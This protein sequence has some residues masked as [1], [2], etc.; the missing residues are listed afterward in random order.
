MWARLGGARFSTSDIYTHTHTH[1]YICIGLASSLM[2]AILFITI[3][4]CQSQKSQLIYSRMDWPS[5]GCPPWP[6]LAWPGTHAGTLSYLFRFTA[7]LKG[8]KPPSLL[9]GTPLTSFLV[10]AATAAVAA[11]AA[12]EQTRN[13]QQQ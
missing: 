5:M 1:L 3:N 11:P 6:G 8:C 10:G 12:A 9:S 2:L 4:N 7:H 13:K